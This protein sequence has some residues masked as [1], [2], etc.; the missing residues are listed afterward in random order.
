MSTIEI[1][2]DNS[3]ANI[4]NETICQSRVCGHKVQ[5]IDCG[6]EVSK[7]LSSALGLPNLRLIRQNDN[8]NK[9]KGMLYNIKL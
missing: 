7:W 8:D 3:S 9:K 4:A 5:G 1:P 2:L 6:S